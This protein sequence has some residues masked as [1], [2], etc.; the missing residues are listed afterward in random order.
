V[1]VPFFFLAYSGHYAHLE[2]KVKVI[3]AVCQRKALYLAIYLTLCGS[4]STG[5]QPCRECDIRLWRPTKYHKPTLVSNAT[6]NSRYW[7]VDS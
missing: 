1:L 7:P 3:I 6:S 4:L 5:P 2:R